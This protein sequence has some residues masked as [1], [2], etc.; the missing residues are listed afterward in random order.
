[1]LKSERKPSW[2]KIKI[3]GGEKYSEIKKLVQDNNLHTICSSGRCPNIGECWSRGAAT[4]MILGDI[5]TRQCKFC[6]T[7][8]GKPLPIDLTEPHSIAK[9]V[10]IMKLKHGVITSVDRDDLPDKGAKHWANVI[11]E[12]KKVNPNTIIEVLLPDFDAIPELIKIVANAKPDIL[13]HNIETIARLTPTIRSRAK[14]DVSLQTLKLFSETG[15]DTKS[16]I[17]VG[18]GETEQEVIETMKDLFNAGCRLLT[19]GQYLQPNPENIEVAEYIHPDT[20]AKYKKIAIEMG[21]ISAECGPL[22]RSSYMAENSY[23]NSK[24]WEVM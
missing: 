17:M 2:L 18:L 16:G 3:S 21:Y 6:A 1:M 9:S 19:I 15:I 7:K 22:V 23:Q 24:K 4:F 14:Y 20:F 5:C 8:T 10:K 13:S 12:I 11:S